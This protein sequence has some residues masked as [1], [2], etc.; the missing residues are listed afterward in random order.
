M[1]EPAM[2]P[3]ATNAATPGRT[4]VYSALGREMEFYDLDLATAGLERI[5]SIELDAVIQYAW[6]NRARTILYVATSDSGPMAKVKLPNHFV[7]ALR[8]EPTGAL[9]PMGPSVKLGNRPL[10]LSLDMAERHLLL[11]YNDP[12]EVTVHR[13]EADGAIGAAVDQPPLDLGITPH[14]IRVTPFDTIALVPACGHHDTGEAPGTLGVYS[15]SDGRLA[16]LA[17]LVPEGTD[18]APW[19]NVCHG[20]QGFAPRHVDFHPDRPWMYLCVETQGEIQLYDYDRDGIASN[21]RFTRSTLEGTRRGRS[22]QLASAIHVH[23]NGRFVYVSNRADDAEEVDGLPVFVGGVNDIAVFAIDPETGEPTLIQ[24]AETQGIFPRTFGIDPTGRVLVAANQDPGWVRDGD[25][26]RRVLPS[27][28]V[29]RIGD[30]GRLDF[31]RRLD[32]PDDG[33]VCFWAGVERIPARPP[34]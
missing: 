26:V 34:E 29:F 32:H 3:V 31:V 13:I 23:P 30:D 15:Y 20:A 16:P 24:H 25:T 21:P 28:V 1:T 11:A 19:R 14:Q 2:P 8:I 6:P 9:T 33:R 17:T 10:H 22:R 7:Q 5:G 12:P 4:I 18:P 27:L